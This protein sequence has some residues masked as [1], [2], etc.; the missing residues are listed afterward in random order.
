MNL[1]AA[2]V[3]HEGQLPA[4]EQVCWVGGEELILVVAMERVAVVQRLDRPDERW[5]VKR[6]KVDVDPERLQWV[7]EETLQWNEYWSDRAVAQRGRAAS[8]RRPGP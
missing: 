1:E 8:R 7:P 6:S 2:I 4:R 5:T 3:A